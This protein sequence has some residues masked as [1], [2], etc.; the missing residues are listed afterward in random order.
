VSWGRRFSVTSFG[1]PV[2]AGGAQ[3]GLC[4]LSSPVDGVDQAFLWDDTSWELSQVS[5]GPDNVRLV[6]PDPTGRW[7]WWWEDGKHQERGRWMRWPTRGGR[8]RPAAPELPAGFPAGLAFRP[9]GTALA[10]VSDLECGV[11][12]FRLSPDGTVTVLRTDPIPFYLVGS[13]P[14]RTANLLMHAA[15]GDPRRPALRL[16]GDDGAVLAELDDWPTGIYVEP[17]GDPVHPDL[18]L[19]LITRDHTGFARPAL[20]DFDRH[21]VRDVPL[22]LDGDLV[23]RFLGPDRLVVHRRHAGVS[24]LFHC[25]LDGSGLTPVDGEWGTVH[26]FTVSPGRDVFSLRSDEGRPPTVYRGTTE[27]LTPAWPATPPARPLTRRLAVDGEGGPIDVLLT[28]SDQDA[29]PAPAVFLV[30]GGPATHDG[31]EWSP[32]AASWADQG[33][34]VVRVNYRGSTGFGTAWQFGHETDVGHAELADIAAVGDH[35]AAAGEIDPA[36]CALLGASWGGYLVLL[37]L[38]TQ[39]GRWT[40]GVAESPIGDY[41]AI[42]AEQ[43]EELRLQDQALFGGTPHEVPDRYRRASPLTYVEDLSAPVLVLI[44]RE[45]PRCPRGQAYRFVTAARHHHPELI[46]VI[47]HE[48]GHGVTRSANATELLAAQG[49]FVDRHT[50]PRHSA[51]QETAR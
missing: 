49:A 37:G 8:P 47:D 9:D 21:E 34:V 46:E 6:A 45:D 44:G 5:D 28:R 4:A 10:A 18:P 13:V 36:R 43:T 42:Y 14:D 20:W 12:L 3:P 29:R 24:S 50:A 30:H 51:A 33:Y 23:P 48:A 2:W 16:H 40:C 15:N 17:Y 39:P 41:A 27:V 1:L 26:G 11:C 19:A 35:L 25:A 32:L 7:I 38:C 31:D 22:A